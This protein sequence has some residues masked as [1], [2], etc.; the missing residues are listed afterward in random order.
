MFLEL[1]YVARGHEAILTEIVT[2]KML[3][4]LWITNTFIHTFHEIQY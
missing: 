1:T 2:L 3:T 4:S